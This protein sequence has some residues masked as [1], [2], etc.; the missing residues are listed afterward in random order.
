MICSYC[1]L[2]DLAG[3]DFGG[4]S[5]R[6]RMNRNT[7]IAALYKIRFFASFAEK[8]EVTVMAMAISYNWLFLWDKNQSI[9]GV[10]LLVLI[11]GVSGHNCKQK[12]I[13]CSYSW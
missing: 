9:N 8:T 7:E 3:D 6:P 10:K 4:D 13:I 2:K 11:T 5:N 1:I 12:S